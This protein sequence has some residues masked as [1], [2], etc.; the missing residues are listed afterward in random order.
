MLIIKFALEVLKILK[1]NQSLL[2]FFLMKL[3]TWSDKKR[4]S[5]WGETYT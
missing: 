5:S 1:K 4:I 3:M 2:K